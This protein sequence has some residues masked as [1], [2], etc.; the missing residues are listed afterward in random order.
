MQGKA[1]V[2]DAGGGVQGFF[3]DSVDGWFGRPTCEIEKGFVDGSVWDCSWLG[4]LQSPFF[5]NNALAFI[6]MYLITLVS[7]IRTIFATAVCLFMKHRAFFFSWSTQTVELIINLNVYAGFK[8]SCLYT[9]RYVIFTPAINDY[10][11]FCVPGTCKLNEVTL[12]TPTIH[13]SPMQ[14][15]SQTPGKVFSIQIHPYFNRPL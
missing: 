14:D 1:C 7:I 6:Y 4:V 9:I 13:R 12:H 5:F 10:P 2:H 3:L 15:L 8:L 11:I